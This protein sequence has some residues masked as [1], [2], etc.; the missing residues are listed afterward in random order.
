MWHS[1]FIPLS[2]PRMNLTPS[3]NSILETKKNAL[4]SYKPITSQE[5]GQD[6]Q[7]S[8]AYLWTWGVMHVE[9]ITTQSAG[10]NP[11]GSWKWD[12]SAQRGTDLGVICIDVNVKTWKN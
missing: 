11:A 6:S 4:Y 12:S 2:I 7:P 3:T 9:E 5:V 10:V 1:L 8:E